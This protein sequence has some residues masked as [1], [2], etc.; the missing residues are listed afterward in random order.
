LSQRVHLGLIPLL[1]SVLP[2]RGGPTSPRDEL[3]TSI[4]P[5]GKVDVEVQVLDVVVDIHGGVGEVRGL[6]IE[7]GLPILLDGVDV[8][9]LLVQVESAACNSGLGP[10]LAL[11]EARLCDKLVL[12]AR[13]NDIVASPSEDS[14]LGAVGGHGGDREEL[15]IQEQEDVLIGHQELND[16]PLVSG[17][18]V[19]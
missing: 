5:L 19:V 9:L 10:I 15:L 14:R 18:E 8:D 13:S 7:W 12:R 16:F 2:N 4:S 1:G 6:R 11:R 17:S 3:L